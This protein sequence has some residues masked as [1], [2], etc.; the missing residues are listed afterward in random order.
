M[1]FS[2]L[3]IYYILIT[4]H[5]FWNFST[6]LLYHPRYSLSLS[7][8]TLQQKSETNKAKYDRWN[9]NVHKNCGVYF[10]LASYWAWNLPWSVVE[11]HSD[12][13]L[14]KKWFYLSSG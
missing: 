4:F 10:V 13:T 12:T 2:I 9:K 14:E 5:N 3:F 6:S 7:L 8:S 11:R 1:F